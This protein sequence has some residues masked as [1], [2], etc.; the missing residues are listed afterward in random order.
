MSIDLSRFHA[1]FFAESRQGLDA[2]ENDMLRIEQGG[3]SKETMDAIFRVVHS[4]KGSA[5]SLGFS[6]IAGL[7]HEMESVLDRLRQGTLEA[8]PACTDLLLRGIDRLRSWLEAAEAN[9]PVDAAEG[10]DIVRNLQVQMQQV[11]TGA[12]SAPAAEA[13]PEGKQRY[14]VV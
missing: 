4:L 9:Q 1:T 12:K 11:S 13:K 6:E 7:A 2:V 3:A 8:T 5:G 14:R 10:A